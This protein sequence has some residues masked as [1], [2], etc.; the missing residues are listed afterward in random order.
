MQNQSAVPAAPPATNAVQPGLLGEDQMFRAQ[1]ATLARLVSTG[2]LLDSRGA[3]VVSTNIALLGAL[4]ASVSASS[5]LQSAGLLG[6]L[7]VLLAAGGCV[8]S[9]GMAATAAFPRSAAASRSIV[10]FG[11]IAAMSREGYH[12]RMHSTTR[13]EYGRDLGDQ[14]HFVATIVTFKFTWVRRAMI[15]LIATAVPWL[16]CLALA[17]RF[18]LG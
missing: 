6:W 5:Y 18:H 11:G 3:I 8:A 14:C 13:A 9:I 1:E 16:I 15:T 12:A 7:F 2:F 10:F 4:I 17:G